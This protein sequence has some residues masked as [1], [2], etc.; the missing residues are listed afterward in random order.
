MKANVS[1][2]FE[3]GNKEDVGNRPVSLTL[4]Y[5][6]VMECLILETI[7]R[8]IT[9]EKIIRSSLH[10]FTKG[11][12]CLTNLVNSYEE[13]TGLGDEER[14]VNIVYSDFRKSFDIYGSEGILSMYIDA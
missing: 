2:I 3:K 6:K 13:L 9:D 8:H 14:A 7:A 4:I 5:E 11:K 10:H 12:L 1:S